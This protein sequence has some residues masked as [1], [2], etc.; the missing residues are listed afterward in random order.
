MPS[1]TNNRRRSLLVP[2]IRQDGLP[3]TSQCR[4]D[5]IL[6]AIYPGLR[7]SGRGTRAWSSGR[8]DHSIVHHYRTS[9]RHGVVTSFRATKPAALRRDASSSWHCRACGDQNL[10]N[11]HLAAV[12]TP[13]ATSGISRCSD[14]Q[15]IVSYILL[16]INPPQQLFAR[17]SLAGTVGVGSKEILR[18]LRVS[19]NIACAAQNPYH[20][21]VHPAPVRATCE[22][23][24][25]DGRP[26]GAY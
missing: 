14:A 11:Q 15:L 3:V 24:E 16:H 6:H 25:I 7:E 10:P 21:Y 13:R 20:W 17:G 23:T 4:H 8:S 19:V 1:N 26:P 2:A 22:L 9:A 5:D 12:C 18:L